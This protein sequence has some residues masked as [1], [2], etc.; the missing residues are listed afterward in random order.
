MKINKLGEYH[1]LYVQSDTLLLPDVF[2]NFRSNCIEIYELNFL[3]APRLGWQSCL[4]KTGVKFELLT[5]INMPLMVEI[6][7]RGGIVFAIHKHAKANNK[8]LD[9][10]YKN[11]KSSYLMYFYANNLYG[12]AMSQKLPVNGFKW[13]K[14]YLNKDFIK[15]YHKNCNKGYILQVDAEY[16]KNLLNRHGDLSFSDEWK[17]T[18]KFNK[19]V[20]NIN[21][22]EN[23]IVHIADLKKALNHGLIPKKV[24]RVI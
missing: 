6:G 11:I 17:K 1:D 24:H 22:K 13:K 23:S 3:S 19:L 10:N 9:N 18:K 16:L 12:W 21:D 2:G 15:N 8:Y 5:D 7:S 20:C 14:T 4:T